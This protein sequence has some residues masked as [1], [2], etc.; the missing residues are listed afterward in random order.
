MLLAINIAPSGTENQVIKL[1]YPGLF[2]KTS[3]ESKKLTVLF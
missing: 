1:D 2:K 3:L